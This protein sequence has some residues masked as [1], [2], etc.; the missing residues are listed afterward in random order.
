MQGSNSEVKNGKHRINSIPNE[1]PAYNYYNDCRQG[2]SIVLS[3]TS[4]RPTTNKKRTKQD[5][6]NAS[7]HT[8]TFNFIKIN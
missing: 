4:Q 7:N 6:R 3:T 2:R 1:V 8:S 5:R